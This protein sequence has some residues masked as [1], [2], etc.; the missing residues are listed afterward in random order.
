[1]CRLARA[2]TD[3]ISDPGL[4]YAPL[5]V[6]LRRIVVFG[7]RKHEIPAWAVSTI[8]I[9]ACGDDGSSSSETGT[10]DTSGTADTTGTGPGTSTT[11]TTGSTGADTGTTGMGSTGTATGADST[12]TTG[13]VAVCEGGSDEP[14]PEPEPDLV[15]DTLDDIVADDGQLSLREAVAQLNAGTLAA[16][17]VIGFDTSLSGT[18]TLDSTLSVDESVTIVGHDANENGAP[19]IWLDYTTQGTLLALEGANTHEYRLRWLGLSGARYPVAVQPEASSDISLTVEH[20]EFTAQAQDGGADAAIWVDTGGPDG[21]GAWSLVVRHSYFHDVDTGIHAFGESNNVEHSVVIDGCVFEDAGNDGSAILLAWVTSATIANTVV[22]G[23]TEY[24]GVYAYQQQDLRI[25]S[26][27]IVG[28]STAPGLL[29]RDSAI[30]LANTVLAGNGPDCAIDT[31]GNQITA[32]YSLVGATDGCDFTGSDNLMGTQGAPVDPVLETIGDYGGP[33]KSMPPAAGSPLI[34]AGSDPLAVDDNDA[35][36]PDDVRGFGFPRRCD[37]DR[38]QTIV[39][40]I[41]ATELEPNG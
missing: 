6:A 18:I 26:S 24:A 37:G 15:V 39:V 35:P 30:E 19:D 5:T 7:M 3:A 29:H 27:T 9:V 41:G 8:L 11:T 10:G 22:V 4:G 17:G 31:A 32:N 23:D 34:D 2:P 25:V 40:D 20:C 12:G 21:N 36:L 38:D 14:E 13:T 28:N 1:M 16:G 33:R